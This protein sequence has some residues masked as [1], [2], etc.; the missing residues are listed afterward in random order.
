M[1]MIRKL[2]ADGYELSDG[3]LIEWPE[4][5]GTIRR[6]DVHGN[7]EEVRRLGDDGYGEWK[8]LFR[9]HR[10]TG[11]PRANTGNNQ[12]VTECRDATSVHLKVI[13]RL[14]RHCAG[15]LPKRL[16]S[17]LDDVCEGMAITCT[18]LDDAVRGLS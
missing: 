8:R 18:K 12:S 17:D 3:G 5:D 14:R 10:R 1:A 11:A 15:R 16:A 4:D 6:R 13:Q 7:T 9:G 2:S